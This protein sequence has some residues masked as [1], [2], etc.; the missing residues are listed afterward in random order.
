MT[1]PTRAPLHHLYIRDPFIG[2]C[3]SKSDK[4][5][6][7]Y[8]YQEASLRA[9]CSRPRLHPV[10]L[11]QCSSNKKTCLIHGPLPCVCQP[12]GP[13]LKIYRL[14]T[15][16]KKPLNPDNQSGEKY[17]LVVWATLQVGVCDYG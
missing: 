1:A 15:P 16:A 14:S 11:K 12:H 17:R 5:R 8:Q 9:I 2:N 6:K 7:Y 13:I 3:Q 4:P 10:Q